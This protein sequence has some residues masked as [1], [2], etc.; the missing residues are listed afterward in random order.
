VD[1][2]RFFDNLGMNGTRW[3]WR[4]MRWQRQWKQAARGEGMGTTDLSISNIILF[5]N[6][7]LF[8]VMVVRGVMAGFGFSPLLHP[9][10]E[11][12][13]VSGGQWW[14]LVVQHGE[15]WRCISYAFTHAGLIHLG[16]NM[17]VLYQVG[18]QLER[19]IGPGGFISLYTVTA[20]AATFLGYIWHPMT[21]VVGA[22]GALFGMIGF[23]ISYFHRIGGHNALAQRDFM[24]RWAFFAFIFGFVV[25]ADNAAHLGGAI[26]GA[27]F[28]LLF[29]ISLRS[30]RA[31]AP[32]TNLIAGLSI[33]ATTASLI[34]LVLSWTG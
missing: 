1:W 3:Q 8:S 26:S 33:V 27:V 22:S 15:W 16:F 21:V 13:V 4:I 23:S 32:A 25:G 9:N 14:P 19:E 20:L 30:R 12:L 5:L 29:P 24:L 17:V 18:P 34:F 7:L 31:L 10:T 6:L 28:G 2:K 11:L